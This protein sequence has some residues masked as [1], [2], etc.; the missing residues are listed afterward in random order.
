MVP[1]YLKNTAQFHRIYLNVTNIFFLG[2][3]SDFTAFDRNNT[4]VMVYS[5]SFVSRVT[6]C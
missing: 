5:Q 6:S 2:L 4:K 3:D 1:M